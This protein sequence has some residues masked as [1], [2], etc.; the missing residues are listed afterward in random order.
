MIY[1][2]LRD[3]EELSRGRRI[4]YSR[5][6]PISYIYARGMRAGTR[7]C[8]ESR[9]IRLAFARS[10]YVYGCVYGGYVDRNIRAVSHKGA[11]RVEARSRF[12]VVFNGR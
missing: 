5:V 12:C 7:V 10:A 9:G 1:Q 4:N 3:L 2:T 11:P 6:S 8:A